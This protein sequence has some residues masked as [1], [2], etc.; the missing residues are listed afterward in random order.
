M[1]IIKPKYGIGEVVIVDCPDDNC[2]R[3]HVG[4]I[5]A[6]GGF[7]PRLNGPA[8]LRELKIGD[9]I[10]YEVQYRNHVFRIIEETDIIKVDTIATMKAAKN[11]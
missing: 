5:I 10:H 6:V 2:R 3:T 7:E 4:T 8:F 11:G 9:T 1:R